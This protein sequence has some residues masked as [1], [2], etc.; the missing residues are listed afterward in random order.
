MWGALTILKVAVR[1]ASQPLH[2]INLWATRQRKSLSEFP[3]GREDFGQD[4]RRALE[5]IAE[6]G[7]RG[8]AVRGD[9][10]TRLKALE[11]T[12]RESTCCPAG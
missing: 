11:I 4:V 5:A 10:D 6:Y 1:P 12:P 2:E 9:N 8:L 7:C 3:D